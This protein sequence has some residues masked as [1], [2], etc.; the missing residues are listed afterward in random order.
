MTGRELIIYILK[1]NLEDV[2]VNSEEFT[3]AFITMFEAAAKL[4]VGLA[5]MKA[6]EQNEII[7]T[8]KFNGKEFVDEKTLNPVIEQRKALTETLEHELNHG[9]K[10]WKD[11]WED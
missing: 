2:D 1:N 5:T 6:F 7:K 11:M 8:F 10:K 9:R 4:N 3:S